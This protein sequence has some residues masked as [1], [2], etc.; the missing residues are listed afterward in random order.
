MQHARVGLGLVAVGFLFATLTSRE[1]RA[2]VTEN[3]DDPSVPANA[4]PAGWSVPPL[5]NA[6]TGPASF[7]VD[8]TNPRG[9]FSGLFPSAGGAIKTTPE[10]I[11]TNSDQTARFAIT[12]TASFVG[13][14]ARAAASTPSTYLCAYVGG[15]DNL[16]LCAASPAYP[17]GFKTIT[18]VGTR[19]VNNQWY[20]MRFHVQQSLLANGNVD[21]TTTNLVVTLWR[22]NSAGNSSHTAP[23]GTDTLLNSIPL[24]F[25]DPAGL[26]SN[27]SLQMRSGYD[28]L[29]LRDGGSNSTGPGGGY[30]DNYHLQDL[31]CPQRLWSQASTWPT[32]V[33]PTAGTPARVTED[34]RC[35]LPVVLDA[36]AAAESVTIE[37]GA[38]LAF[39]P[40]KNLQLSSTHSLVVL[41]TLQMKPDAAHQHTLQFTGADTVVHSDYGGG[42]GP[43]DVDSV[44]PP[45]EMMRCEASDPPDDEEFWRKDVGLW[46]ACAGRLDLQGTP[47]T[48]WVRATGAVN[49][50]AES[51]NVSLPSASTS[52]AWYPQDKIWI[53]PT[54]VV[55]RY[56]D[57]FQEF[58]RYELTSAPTVLGTSATVAVASAQPLAACNTSF[59]CFYTGMAC[60]NHQC[61]CDADLDCAAGNGTCNTTTHTCSFTH[62]ATP[63]PAL[64]GGCDPSKGPCSTAAEVFNTTRD[65]KILGALDSLAHVWI[66]NNTP[67]QHKINYVDIEY[68]G[69]RPG[70]A[71]MVGRYGLHFHHCTSDMDD[72]GDMIGDC[73]AANPTCPTIAGTTTHCQLE[74]G[75]CFADYCAGSEVTGTIVQNSGAH[76]FVPHHSDKI[77]FTDDIAFRTQGS[78]FWWD[79]GDVKR[80]E[81]EESATTNFTMWNHCLA[82]NTYGD[83]PRPGDSIN[84]IETAAFTLGLGTG[85]AVVDSAAVGTAGDSTSSSG[86]EWNEHANG[87]NSLEDNVW[88]FQGNVS[89]NN[90]G[91]GA[92]IWEND[93]RHHVLD[94][95]V[96]YRNDSSGVLHGAYGNSYVVQNSVLFDNGGPTGAGAGT[97]NHPVPQVNMHA[98]SIVN[99]SN[100]CET[101][102]LPASCANTQDLV[103]SG[104][105]YLRWSNIVI[106]AGNRAGFTPSALQVGG[107]VPSFLQQS[108]L[109]LSWK[110]KGQTGAAVSIF[111]PAK[112]DLAGC[113]WSK[114]TPP[115]PL[116]TPVGIGRA[117]D[118]VNWLVGDPSNPT[119][120]RS[121][122]ETD[123][124][125]TN[126]TPDGVCHVGQT[127]ICMRGNN[128]PCVCGFD[129]DCPPGPIVESVP[130]RLR[131]QQGIG[132]NACAFTLVQNPAGGPSFVRGGGATAWGTDTEVCDRDPQTHA[133]VQFYVD[134]STPNTNPP[135]FLGVSNQ[136]RDAMGEVRPLCAGPP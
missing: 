24:A 41:G 46:V 6:G 87:I 9:K 85:N 136:C 109:L 95:F 33:V 56:A 37:D 101:V 103:V 92:Y 84:A 17:N 38:T 42:M 133:R 88:A 35:G 93:T 80:P 71:S 129:S 102:P 130:S 30:V 49:P 66:S 51:L 107:C 75:R 29:Y 115:V 48:G 106:D 67:T 52:L 19:L 112:D 72:M 68:M 104:A 43:Y 108:G 4:W 76:A 47:R 21:S 13:F 83:G 61:V 113:L 14:M 110:V 96:A 39:D 126:C 73:S 1:A 82:A 134:A 54:A 12:K 123:F 97:G 127:D 32:G 50:W 62:P 44:D 34:P 20:F 94:H 8:Q 105:D 118:F 16:A 119:V 78:A 7:G 89:H 18:S 25:H 135:T 121:L 11:A 98:Q 124:V 91:H 10:S 99:G 27:P 117:V 3:W 23:D 28:G 132:E 111:L 90:T 69:P 79:L 77:T 45:D 122:N 59:E 53:A 60:V 2:D 120:Y 74:V 63:L 131:V 36:D 86:F 125:N 58:E 64:P 81:I 26:G 116:P 70:G 5:L 114:T 128:I 15:G 100:E 40:T 31:D 55:H 65:V 22:D 57:A